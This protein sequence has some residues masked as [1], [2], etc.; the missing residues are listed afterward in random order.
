MST[1]NFSIPDK[2]KQRFNKVF[3]DANKS[4]VVTK[5][6]EEAIER[7]E[8]KQASDAAIHAILI[9]HTKSTKRPKVSTQEILKLRDTLRAEADAAHVSSK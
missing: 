3:A 9:R 5:L 1:M 6:L 4:A 7:A 8:R 2:V